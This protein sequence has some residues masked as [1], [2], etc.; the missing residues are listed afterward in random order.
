VSK[1]LAEEAKSF[2]EKKKTAKPTTDKTAFRFY[3]GNILGGLLSHQGAGRSDE[4]FRQAA[5]LATKAVDY[6]K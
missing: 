2:T 1:K 5:D 6:E 4:T 3:F